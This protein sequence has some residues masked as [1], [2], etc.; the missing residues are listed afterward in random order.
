MTLGAEI[1]G[2]LVPVP[3]ERVERAAKVESKAR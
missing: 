1:M 3:A 2:K